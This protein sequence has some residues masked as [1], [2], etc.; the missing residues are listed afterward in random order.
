[1]RSFLTAIV[2]ALTLACS[3]TSSQVGVERSLRP[4]NETIET[5]VIDFT[6]SEGTFLSF[7]VAP[8]GWL[9]TDLLGQLW[10]IPAEGGDAIALTNAVTDAAE[11]MDPVVSPDGRWIAFQ[12]D[13]NGVEGL[14]L[15]PSGGGAPRLLPGTEASARAQW[16]VLYR[17]AWSPDSRE[18]V[19]LRDGRILRHRIEEQTTTV[20]RLE[21]PP[22][23]TPRCVDWIRD[24]RLLALIAPPGGAPAQLWL[25]DV[26]TGRGTAVAARA[27]TAGTG[28]APACPVGSADGNRIAYFV[29]D[30]P[31][32]VGLEEQTLAT[33]QT[34]RLGTEPELLASRVRYSADNTRIFYVADGRIRQITAAGGDSREVPFTARVTFERGEAHLPPVTFNDAGETAFAR[35]HLGLA[36][37]PDGSRTAVFALGKLWMWTPGQDPRP[38]MDVPSTAAW[39]SWAP[40]GTQLAWSAAT[41]DREDIFVTTIATGVTRQLTRI[42]SAAR[43]SWSPDGT[44]IAFVHGALGASRPARITLVRADA[45]DVSDSAQLVSLADAPA[46][47]HPLLPLSE[48]RITWSPASDALLVYQPSCLRYSCI[49]GGGPR[50]DALRIVPLRGEPIALEPLR[51]AATFLH[52]AADSSLIYVHGNQ[53]WRAGAARGTKFGEPVLLANEPALYPSVARDGTILFVGIDGY[54]IRKPDG[55]IVAFGW[56]LKFRIPEPP[57]LLIRGVRIIDGTSALPT[58]PSDVLLQRGRIERIAPAGSIPPQ[59]GV[60][61]LDAAGR[62]LMP[63]LIDLH[64]HQLGPPAAQAYLYHG[65]TTVRD[66][67][68]PMASAAGIADAVE[69]RR[70]PGPRVVLGGVRINPGSPDAFT[71]AAIQATR[72]PQESQRALLLAQAFGASYVKMQ[73]PARW[74]A[75]ADL[76]HQAH[77]LGL[78]IGGHCSH[79]LPLVAAGIAQNEHVWGC[80]ARTQ[81]PPHADLIELY[82]AAGMTLVPT[83]SVFGQSRLQSDTSWARLPDV[84]PFLAPSFRPSPPPSPALNAVRQR[85]FSALR[86]F[87]AAG[88]RITAGTDVG[89]VPGIIH[90]ELEELVAAGLTPVEAIVAVTSGAAQGLGAQEEIGTVEPGKRADLIVVDGNPVEDIRRTRRIWQ[91]I[92]GGWLVDRASLV[93]GRGER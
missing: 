85:Y 72:D 6:V 60:E 11:D 75:G 27:V 86:S 61:V 4:A 87:K 8:D 15:L 12:G 83:L 33:G 93:P 47:W 34:A 35:G 77:A 90:L 76:T 89:D 48:E 38:I 53:L 21:N 23:G 45:Q 2:T 92:R 68:H 20:V 32:A 66:M 1:M 91:V 88:V 10:R 78:R 22:A 70:I 13:R 9:V 55:S 79:P 7:D 81:A 59:R 57:P 69:A 63:G 41:G 40:N 31:G 49:Y 74:S 26:G 71:G 29:E 17:P 67:G 82:R 65:I 30:S 24:G 28:L 52:W 44:R 73:F 46:A 36:L 43:P 19:F 84:A 62:F 3:V 37:S 18:I 58:G 5:R 16:K 25:F 54:R 64:V 80:G 56:P 50:T 39:P 51:D 42:G 14:W